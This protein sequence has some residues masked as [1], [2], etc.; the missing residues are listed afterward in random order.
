MQ[1]PAR[2]PRGATFGTGCITPDKEVREPRMPS[3]LAAN[4][5]AQAAKA[6]EFPPSECSPNRVRERDRGAYETAVRRGR[7]I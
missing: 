5:S 3:P 6:R 1:L 2:A 4:V 7:D